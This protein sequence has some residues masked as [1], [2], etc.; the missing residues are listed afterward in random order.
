MTLNKKSVLAFVL[1][2]GLVIPTLVAQDQQSELDIV[3]SNGQPIKITRVKLK[4]LNAEGLKNELQENDG[5]IVIIGENGE[6][7]EI[8]VSD[9]QSIIVNKSVSSIVRDGEEEKQVSGKAI[10]IGPDGQ[11]QEIELTGDLLGDGGMAQFKFSPMQDG[12]FSMPGKFQFRRFGGGG[13]FAIGVHCRKVSDALR[14]HIDLDEGVGLIVTNEPVDDSP[15][16]EAGIQKHDILT[17]V[18]Q[19]AL[20]NNGDLA[21]AVQDAGAAEQNLSV[22]LLRRGKEIGVT[23]KPVEREQLGPAVGGLFQPGFDVQFEEFGPGLI[24]SGENLVLPAGKDAVMEDLM[25]RIEELDSQFQQRMDDF[26]IL[27][28]ELNDAMQKQDDDDR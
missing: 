21:K 9:A 23:V 6:Q 18:D 12:V 10:I 27:R 2:V 19:I 26:M 28:D 17:M 5:K 24:L 4:E 3:D 25:K 20:N 22:T 7:Q 14:A 1:S 11:R 13:K 8:D 15:A 16:S